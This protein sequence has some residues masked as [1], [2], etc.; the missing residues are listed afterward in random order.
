VCNFANYIEGIVKTIFARFQDIKQG[1]KFDADN[2]SLSHVEQSLNKLG[3]ALRS[4]KDTFRDYGDV[5]GDLSKKWN[6][7][8]DIQQSDMAKSM[9]G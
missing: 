6:T 3:I 5:I 7:L 2:E 1:L 9:A 8:T 4:D